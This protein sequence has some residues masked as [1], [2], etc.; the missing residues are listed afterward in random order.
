[1]EEA[2]VLELW[3]DFGIDGENKLASCLEIGDNFATEAEDGNEEGMDFYLLVCYS[4]PFVVKESFICP[5]GEEFSVGQLAVRGQYYQKW[6][7]GPQNYVYRASLKLLV[8]MLRI[9][10][11]SSFPW[12]PKS[13]GYRVRTQCMHCQ[14]VKLGKV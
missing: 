8:V 3:N 13:I 11:Q 5:W 14:R 7:T 6:S 10:G 9:S 4:K 2:F 1:M 12:F